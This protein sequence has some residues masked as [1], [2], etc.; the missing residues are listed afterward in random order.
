MQTSSDLVFFDN[1]HGVQA[2][3]YSYVFLIVFSLLSCRMD[4][5]RCRV[6]S[7]GSS[8]N[9]GIVV[10]GGKNKLLGSIRCST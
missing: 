10:F 1:N 9:M 4:G 6:I 7:N 2:I 3:H 5:T 8:V